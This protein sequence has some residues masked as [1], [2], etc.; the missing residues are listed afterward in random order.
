MTSVLMAEKSTKEAHVCIAYVMCLLSNL[1]PRQ[2]EMADA[3]PYLSIYLGHDGLNETAKYLKFSNE[4]FPE[5]IDAF[6]D[7]MNGLLPEVD[8]EA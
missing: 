6:G 2:K 8:H 4:L 3:I 1:L 5:A 7:F